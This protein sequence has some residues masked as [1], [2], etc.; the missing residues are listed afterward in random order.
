MKRGNVSPFFHYSSRDFTPCFRGVDANEASFFTSLKRNHH[1]RGL[2]NSNRLFPSAKSKIPQIKSAKP[3]VHKRVYL[4]EN[5]VFFI[6]ETSHLSSFSNKGSKHFG[7][8]LLTHLIY[9]GNYP[10]SCNCASCC[11]VEFF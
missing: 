8:G 2:R 7:N 3:Y 11:V 5:K 1:Q 9:T 6:T 10:T 4:H